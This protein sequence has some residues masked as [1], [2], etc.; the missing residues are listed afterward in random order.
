MAVWYNKNHLLYIY[1]DKCPEVNPDIICDI[2][3]LPPEIFKKG[4][5]ERLNN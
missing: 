2:M 4:L 3:N 5:G 1:L